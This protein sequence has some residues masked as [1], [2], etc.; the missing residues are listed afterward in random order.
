MNKN[1]LKTIIL[2]EI[3]AIS[4]ELGMGEASGAEFLINSLWIGAISKDE[5]IRELCELLAPE[6][7]KDSEERF[8]L[9]SQV[10][11][12]FESHQQEIIGE[13]QKL[14]YD[15]EIEEEPWTKQFKQP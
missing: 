4:E 14:V 1:T 8:S 9:K 10:L 12:V 7:A 15:N 3:R 6:A 5:N 11:S 13:L 2:E